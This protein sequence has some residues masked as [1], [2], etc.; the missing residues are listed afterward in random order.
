MNRVRMMVLMCAA[1][2]L[3]GVV[4]FLAYRVFRDKMNPKDQVAVVVVNQRKLE[5]GQKL[6]ET[7]LRIAQWP[8]SIADAFPSAKKGKEAK[9]L[10]KDMKDLVGRAVITPM[11]PNEPILESKLAPKDG[12]AGLVTKIPDGMRAVSVRVNDVI[13][14]AGFVIPG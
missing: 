3:A 9:D 7:D 6:E 2:G 11:E 12:G 4:T 14:V 8:Q 1:L 10:D 5:F 13:G